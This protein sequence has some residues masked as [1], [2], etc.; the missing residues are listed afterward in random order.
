[1]RKKIVII[2]IYLLSNVFM[3]ITIPSHTVHSKAGGSSSAIEAAPAGASKDAIRRT[4]GAPG[5][6]KVTLISIPGLSF[7]ELKPPFLP[8]SS[9]LRTMI[10][11]GSIAAL[12]VRT[13]LRGVEDSYLSL[14]AGA[15]SLGSSLSQGM[16][17]N[18][19]LNGISAMQLY[20]RYQGTSP[21]SAE[22]IVPDI[23]AL[24]QINEDQ[25][26]GAQ[27]G[28]LGNFMQENKIA[29]Y[30]FGNRDEGMGH[31]LA[32][33]TAQRHAP[34][35]LMNE[36]GWIGAGDISSRTVLPAPEM[37]FSV[38]TNYRQMYEQWDT[39]EESSLVLIELGDL[40]RLYSEQEKYSADQLSRMKQQVLQEIDQFFKNIV[41]GMTAKDSLWIFSPLANSEALKEKSMLVPLVHYEAGLQESLLKSLTTRRT[42]IVS[43]FDMAPTLLEEFGI[44]P[45]ANLRGLPLVSEPRQ[46]ALP[47][48]QQE[49]DIVEQVYVLRLRLLYSFATYEIIVLL[50]SLLIVLRNSR[51]G[52]RWMR[53]PLLSILISPFIM[54][55]MGWLAGT[56]IQF[57]AAYFIVVLIFASWLL[58]RMPLL[59]SLGIAGFASALFII[60]DGVTGAYAIKRSVLG[61][62][63]MIGARYYGIGNE[64]MGVLIGAVILGVSVWLHLWVGKR[65]DDNPV[66]VK[67]EK[68]SKTVMIV[69]A[70]AFVG[71]IAYLGAP[72]L[73]TNAGGA[74]TATVAFGLAWVRIFCGG[75]LA[76]IRWDRLAMLI[77]ALFIA[78]FAGLWLLNVV[79]P[80]S[81]NQQSHIGR[82]MNVLLEGRLDIIGRMMLRKLEMNWYL[83]GVSSWS[84]VLLTSLFVMAVMVLRPWGVFREWQEQYP[85]IMFG[86]SA[87]AV[88]AI[89]ALIFNDSGI[90]AAATMIVYV[91]VPML[92]L[93]LRMD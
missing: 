62:D 93:K 21:G 83:I 32:E 41:S 88:G 87:S 48:L 7:N 78:A 14:G 19:L 35:M 80:S 30:V 16:H 13:P 85:Y 22:I 92:L 40:D 28:L 10:R 49:L 5:N 3:S 36:E 4:A 81:S 54:L 90:V 1:M 15:P 50:L 66:R 56:S 31:D 2:L 38:K 69:T 42:G 46:R 43:S 51:S 67:A 76:E 68:P 23:A 27:T 84:K 44:E 25:S 24:R 61:Y 79:I 86:F 71:I 89:T 52:L 34:L 91:A 59:P 45:P 72:N 6:K 73:G 64:F 82:A 37:P 57:M 75:R 8:S 29:T 17:R 47:W 12:N 11:K 63:P 55:T 33:F 60:A 53:I 74:I 58:S 70:V 20:T 39:I 18:E 77:A 9:Y 26:Y 65:D